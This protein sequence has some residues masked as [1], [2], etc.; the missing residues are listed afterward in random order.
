M[1]SIKERS[2]A[3]DS[4]ICYTDYD[5]YCNTAKRF[6][7][8][9]EDGECYTITDQNTPRQ[10]LNMLYNDKFVSVVANKGEG[11]TA[12]GGFYNR[13]TKYYKRE[14]YIV[15]DLD[16]K[17]YLDVTDLDSGSTVDL[18]DCAGNICNVRA[19]CSE[20]IGEAEGIAFSVKVFV[21]RDAYCECWA[22]QLR[23]TGKSDRRLRLHAGQAW[24]F[25]NTLNGYG[26]KLPC[27]DIV[28]DKISDG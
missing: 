23:N 14:F 20:F 16:G 24:G 12:F 21:P 4:R 9:S 15:R 28:T 18:F 2:Y 3:I 17:R 7:D 27:E 19:G 11:Y 13:V 26:R 10:W 22:V 8:F 5:T 1:N 25:N 6:G